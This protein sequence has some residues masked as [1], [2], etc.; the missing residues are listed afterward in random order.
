MIKVKIITGNLASSKTENITDLSTLILQENISIQGSGLQH[1]WKNNAG[2]NF[3]LFGKV[4]GERQVG[5][6]ILPQ[7]LN[8][9]STDRLETPSNISEIEGRFIIVKFSSNSNCEVWTDQ[10][11][12]IDIYWQSTDNSIII[13]TELDMLPIAQNGSSLDS[14]GVAHSLTVYGSR[15]AKQHTLYK[16]VHRLGV[17]Q[18]LKLSNG[19]YQIDKIPFTLTKTLINPGEKDLHRYTDLFLEAI[20][21]RASNEGN[22]VYLSSGWDSTSILAA[23]IH[24]FG[25]RKVRAVIGRMRY[26]DRSG[27]INQFELDR[28]HAIAK[29]YGVKLDIIELD[30][31]NNAD[32]ILEKLKSNFRSQQFAN[33]TGFNHWLLAEGTAKTANSNEVIFAGE[34]SDGAHNLGFS[35]YATIFHPASFEFRE[36]SDKMASYLFGPTFLNQLHKNTHEKDPVWQLFKQRYSKTKFDTIAGSEKEITKQLLASFFLRGGRIPLFSL[37]NTPLLTKLGRENYS[38]ES[39]KTYIN[40][41]ADNLELDQ[42]YAAYLHLYNS[43]HWQGSTVSTLERTAETHGLQCVNPFHDSAIIDFLS[44]MPETWGRGLDLNPTKYPLKWM[45]RNRIDYPN[46][47]Q[48]GPHSYTYDVIPD[49]SLV[50]E[51]LHVS[52]FNS[53]FKN[54]LKDSNFIQMLD[55]ATFNHEY[56]DGIVKRYVNGEEL[57]GQ[58]MNDIGVLAVH[59]AIGVYGQ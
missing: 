21:A 4:V 46:H 19:K 44:A 25:N 10:F 34:M 47:L 18:K 23:L 37:E 31:R 56:I 43:F 14:V 2:D 51:L 22:V 58:E 53:V 12:R 7:S 24:I 11:G 20:R 48:V 39:E 17:N 41:V 42:L 30:Y 5:G 59:S 16:D 8:K 3:F 57:R 13:S 6:M 38:Y 52:S 29:Y 49:F 45:L 26:S 32:A 40:E 27:V 55:S 36:Y 28:A 33:L 15:P 54:S 9:L 50:G 35:Q 1:Q